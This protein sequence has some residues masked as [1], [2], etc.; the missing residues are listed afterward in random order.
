ML[1]AFVFRRF[2]QLTIPAGRW[3]T[4]TLTPYLRAVDILLLAGISLTNHPHGGRVTSTLGAYLRAVGSGWSEISPINHSGRGWVISTLTAYFHAFGKCLAGD[5]RQPTTNAGGRHRPS[6]HMYM[7]LAL[8]GR[9][10]RQPDLPS[11]QPQG[12]ILALEP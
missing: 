12:H 7:L 5:F 8:V 4:S 1:L 2:R 9:R 6:L 3:V 11:F 10:F